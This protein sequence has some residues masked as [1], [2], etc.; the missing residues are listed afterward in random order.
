MKVETAYLFSPVG[1]LKLSAD[2]SGIKQICF[3]S[4][5]EESADLN[6]S[7]I[8]LLQAINQLNE[9]F[10]HQR[11]NFDV[12]LNPDG[13]TFQHRIWEMLKSISFGETTTYSDLAKKMG[14][15]KAMRAVGRA[16]GTNKIPIIIPCH[17]VI[18]T[19]GSL[20]G[21]AGGLDRKRLLLDHERQIKQ[22]ELF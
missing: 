11:T 22:S 16:N 17:R 7:N 12:A 6:I 14:N 9:Y 20:I 8:H 4:T 3:S 10:N 21:F 15:P 19:N 5:P 18:G 1:W 2:G 13:T